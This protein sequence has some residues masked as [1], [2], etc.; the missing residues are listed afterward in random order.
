[1]KAKMLPV[2]GRLVTLIEQDAVKLA[3]SWLKDVKKNTKLPSY[4]NFDEKE[5]FRRAEEVFSQLGKWVAWE[6]TREDVAEQY[7]S[8]GAER[9]RQEFQLSEVVQALILMRIHLWRK[10]LTDGLLDTA[11]EFHQA[12]ELNTQVVRYFDRA[13]YYTIIGYTQ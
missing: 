3:M 6:T 9:R 7:V 11:E 5:L 12:L 1:M 8:H 2:A 13:I 4:H 10:V